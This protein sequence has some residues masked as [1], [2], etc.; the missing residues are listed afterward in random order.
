M[1]GWDQRHILRLIFD[2]ATWR[3]GA[4]VD[5]AALERDPDGRY[6][7]RSP[8]TRL[9]AEVIRD[10]ALWASGLLVEHVGGPSVKPYQP[11]G[12]WYAVGYTSSNTARFV[13]DQGDKLYRRSLYTFW[14]RTAPP[15]VMALFDAP[16][17]ESCVVQR[18]RTN[19]PLQALALMNDVQFVE[20]ARHFGVWMRA[21]GDD[22]TCLTRGFE[23]ALGRPATR[24]E[25]DVLRSLLQDQ[26]KLFADREED[27]TALLQVGDT[28]P[29]D[30]DP[31]DFAAWTMVAQTLLNADAFVTRP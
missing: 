5:E 13:Q 24:R 29:P 14:K 10:R 30:G 3:Q 19:T 12:I 15:P 31:I 11:P 16:T 7:S 22:E 18:S 17:R 25:L 8:R 1:S 4:R 28:P 26:R 2:S 20:A 6:L 27:A 9:D 21:Q 23:R